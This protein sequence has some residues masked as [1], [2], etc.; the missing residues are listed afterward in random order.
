MRP[1][2]KPSRVDFGK[3]RGDSF[4][5]LDSKAPFRGVFRPSGGDSRRRATD[6][7][8]PIDLQDETPR[9]ANSPLDDRLE[10]SWLRI[11]DHVLV[12]WDP[13]D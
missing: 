4:P 9:D 6:R 10:P 11:L 3:I 5:S 7:S 8:D 12:G 2:R 1:N 13:I